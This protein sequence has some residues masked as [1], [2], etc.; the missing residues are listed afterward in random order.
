MGKIYEKNA[1]G[2]RFLHMEVE[3]SKIR[4]LSSYAAPPTLAFVLTRTSKC[5]QVQ[6]GSTRR[7]EALLCRPLDGRGHRVQALSDVV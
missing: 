7:A 6:S 3:F 2:Y 1:P 4:P 5:D